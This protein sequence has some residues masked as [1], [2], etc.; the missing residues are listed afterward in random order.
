[1]GAGGENDS[2]DVSDMRVGGVDQFAGER[3]P[4]ASVE[5]DTV[6]GDSEGGK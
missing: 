1:M 3:R 4:A 6:G 5:L 2:G